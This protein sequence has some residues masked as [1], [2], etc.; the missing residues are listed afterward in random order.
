MTPIPRNG[1]DPSTFTLDDLPAGPPLPGDGHGAS[2]NGGI[3][4]VRGR[5]TNIL[6]FIGSHLLVC[7]LSVQVAFTLAIIAALHTGGP[8][9]PVSPVVARFWAPSQRG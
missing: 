9:I 5:K 8:R 3:K 1:P 6:S 2:I 7:V 4:M